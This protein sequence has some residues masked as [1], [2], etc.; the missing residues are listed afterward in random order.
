M[1]EVAVLDREMYT[2]ASAA[3][4]LRLA[5]PTLHYW[6]EGGTRRGKTYQ[7]IIRA[8]ATGSNRVTWAEFIEAGLV[9]Q[10]RRVHHVP[11][12]ELRAVIEY[13]RDK[14]GV[15]YPL[16]HATPYV[17]GRQLLMSAQEHAG[18]DA[19]F[20]LVAPVSGQYVLL[21]PAETFFQRVTWG[22]DLALQWRPDERA[23]SP[24]TIDPDV[25]FGTPAVGGIST[26]ILYEQSQ[27][28]EDESDLA[29]LFN[30][31]VPQ[32]RWA[33]SYELANR[34]A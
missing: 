12:A 3:R 13:L 29:E 10:Y 11:M 31:T 16:A 27:S 17:S 7:P 14:M 20:A 34:A 32:V 19:D 6:L 5:Q 24:V 33:L 28:G 23:D 2:E 1:T 9:R 15:P 22:A 8:E 4:L 21:P 25:R 18:L 30:L 26:E